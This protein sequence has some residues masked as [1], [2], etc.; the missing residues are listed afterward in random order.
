MESRKAVCTNRYCIQSAL[1]DT[2][3]LQ[4]TPYFQ[5]TDGLV[6]ITDAKYNLSVPN[7]LNCLPAIKQ[8]LQPIQQGMALF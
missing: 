6:P 1:Q 3:H 8:F 5:R 2:H 7:G 4:G